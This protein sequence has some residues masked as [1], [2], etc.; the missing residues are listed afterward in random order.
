MKKFLTCLGL[1]GAVLALAPAAFAAQAGGAAA[2]GGNST[3]TW[4]VITAGFA[5]AIASGLCGIGQGIASMGASQGFARNPAASTVIQ[6]M[7][8]LALV[9]IESLALYTFV[10]IFVKVK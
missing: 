9:F 1:T 7:F 6:N 3:A 2:A 10:I 4:V 8:I 5:M